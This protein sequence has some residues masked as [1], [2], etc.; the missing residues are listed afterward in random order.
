MR[1]PVSILSKPCCS[2]RLAYSASSRAP[3]AKKLGE[4]SVLV[5]DQVDDAVRDHDVVGR[6]S[7][8]QPFRLGLDELDVPGAERVGA[9]PCLGDHLRGHVD[10]SDAAFGANHLGSDERV[11]ASAGAEVEYV[12]ARLQRPERERV[13]DPG[14]RFGRA[15]WDARKE[16]GRVAEA[17]P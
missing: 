7:K 4:D 11:G 9:C 10:P 5:G 2:R 6:I 12:L 8:G 1:S 16:L 13:G 17:R 14:E 15:V 3:A